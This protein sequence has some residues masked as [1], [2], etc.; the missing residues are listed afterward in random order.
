MA[1]AAA[2]LATVLVR[3]RASSFE[4]SAHTM[5]CFVVASVVAGGL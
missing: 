3:A 1:V 2:G 4:R 5:P